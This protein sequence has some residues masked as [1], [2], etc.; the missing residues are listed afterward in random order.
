MGP[1]T[2]TVEDAA[3]AL[4]VMAG[5]DPEDPV[6]AFGWQRVPPAYTAFLDADGLDGARIGALLDLFGDEAVHQEVNGGG[7]P[8]DRAH[9]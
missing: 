7:A 3:R 9:E 1:I 5:Y 6:T 2:R 8:C 4:T